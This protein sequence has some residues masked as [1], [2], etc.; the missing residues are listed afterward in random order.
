MDPTW[1]MAA[2]SV[3][4]GALQSPASGP[5]G[6]GTGGYVDFGDSPFVV[7]T[8]SGSASATGSTSTLLWVAAVIAGLIAW[9]IANQKH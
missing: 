1:I 3:V 6:S 8:G 9:K 2:A 5:T 7:N 4:G